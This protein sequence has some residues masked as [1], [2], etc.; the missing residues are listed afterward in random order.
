MRNG[1]V[2]FF[3]KSILIVVRELPWPRFRRMFSV[4]HYLLSPKTRGFAFVSGNTHVLP[5]LRS[6]HTAPEAP[7]TLKEEPDPGVLAVLLRSRSRRLALP[8]G[9]VCNFLLHV[10]KALDV[11]ELVSTPS[12]VLPH[13]S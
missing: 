11:F 10:G 9:S 7:A 13:P 1:Q 12:L 5:L 4:F 6:P 2:L 8:S 3:P